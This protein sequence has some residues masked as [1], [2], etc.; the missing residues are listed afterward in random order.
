MPG[1][2][3]G[4]MANAYKA[5]QD[6]AERRVKLRE[7]LL[8]NGYV[9]NVQTP[10][11][12]ETKDLKGVAD[13]I[14]SGAAQNVVVLVGAGISVSAGIPDFRSPGTGLYANLQKYDLPTPE[15]IFDLQYFTSHPDAFYKL[16]SEIWPDNF[17][18]TP[19]HYFLKRLQ[20][21][22][23]LL[24]VYTQNIDSLET[25]AG[26]DP[27]KVV[28]VHGNFDSAYVVGTGAP[29]PIRELRDAVRAGKDGPGGW[30]A[31]S[32][33][34]RGLVKPG[35]TFFG[36]KVPDSF[37]EL[38]VQDFPKCDLLIV[39]GTSL[40]VEPFAALPGAVGPHVPRLLINRELSASPV[41]TG[42]VDRVEKLKALGLKDPRFFDLASPRDV[43][44]PGDC[45]AAIAEL[46]RHLGW[47]A[48]RPRKPPACAIA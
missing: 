34:Y 36:E 17:T 40:S 35:I 8:S 31:L 42:D 38:R 30:R 4:P 9:E 47:T 14:L 5:D 15:S 24:R 13:L 26:V 45:D 2:W 22:G 43:F 29:V 28:A 46:S 23:V 25:A 48:S 6:E 16:A 7:M 3:A 44:Q 39:M 12:L 21:H 11:L 32:E 37:H 20:D 41:G 27:A 18:P 10:S 33:R 1:T 19:T